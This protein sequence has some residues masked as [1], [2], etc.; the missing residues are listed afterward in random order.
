MQPGIFPSD[1]AISPLPAC[2]PSSFPVIGHPPNHVKPTR[3]RTPRRDAPTL[4]G[5]SLAITIAAPGNTA[6]RCAHDTGVAKSGR[7]PSNTRG[8]ASNQGGFPPSL[9][10][11]PFLP[12]NVAEEDRQHA[13]HHFRLWLVRFSSRYLVCE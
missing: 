1:V 12:H 7:A 3:Y 9:R 8:A 13:S 2:T 4:G 6:I 11:S 5:H 10:F